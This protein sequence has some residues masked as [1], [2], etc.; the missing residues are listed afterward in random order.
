MRKSAPWSFGLAAPLGRE[1][2]G[3]PVTQNSRRRQE[4]AWNQQLIGLAKVFCDC[5]TPQKALRGG[6]V[7]PRA[8]IRQPG[9]RS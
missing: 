8:V 2:D 3:N 9:R 4:V 6:I 1:F 5:E 7:P